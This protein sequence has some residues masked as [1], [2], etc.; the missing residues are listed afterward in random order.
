LEN[1]RVVDASL[2]PLTVRGNIHLTVLMLAE[3]LSDAIKAEYAAEA[4]AEA[5]EVLTAEAEGGG[6]SRL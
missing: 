1:L 5:V 2:L 3:K 4:E 6:R